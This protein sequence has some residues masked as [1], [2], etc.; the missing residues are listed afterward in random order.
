MRWSYKINI[1]L[2]LINK[3][4]SECDIDY[5]NQLFNCPQKRKVQPIC[6]PDQVCQY[7]QE[8]AKFAVQNMMG[9]PRIPTT[10]TTMTTEITSTT[11]VIT[12]DEEV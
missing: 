6:L 11:S 10:T 12:T 5:V 3:Y 8:I 9:P 2:I 1:V 4:F 7:Q